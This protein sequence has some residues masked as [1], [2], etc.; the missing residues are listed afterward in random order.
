[1][2]I[3]V[4]GSIATDHL[5]TFEGRFAEQL[6]AD[7]LEQV[8]LSFLVDE[9]E[10][11][12]GGVAANISFALGRLGLH[13][14]LVGAVGADFD[15]Y[16]SWLERHG[17]DTS[18][19]HVSEIRHTA[20]FVCTTDRD[21]NQIAS[22]YAGAMAEAR[23]IELWPLA[24][25]TGGFDLVLIGADDP[26]GMLRHSDECRD[27]GIPFAADPSQQ[28]AR[29]GGREVRRLIEG[30]AYLFTNEYEKALA[31]RKTKWSEAEVLERVGV[32]ITTLGGKGV[33][34][35]RAGEPPLHVPAAAVKT[36][37]VDPTGV[38][39]AF[40]A[41]FLAGLSW[42]L[43]LERCA[44]LGNSVAAHSLEVDGPQE[45]HLTRATLLERIEISYGAE[46]AGEVAAHV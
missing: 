31:E 33:R 2:R 46:A 38:G 13:P 32:R 37:I 4:T 18:G 43:T 24:E 16:R 3:A 5:M 30:A 11:R 8:S 36:K 25:R 22:F 41:G 10:V 27:R 40:R 35:E 44:Q 21:H 6:I 12:R 42:N 19:V 9:L 39:D 28:L 1:M 29:M 15:E 26:E 34:I 14:V 20:R 45:Y 17:V 7:Q 23:N